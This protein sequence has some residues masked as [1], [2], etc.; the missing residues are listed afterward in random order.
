MSYGLSTLPWPFAEDEHAF[1]Y[2]VNVEE[3]RVHRD[4][5]GGAWGDH[6]IE[7]GDDYQ[8]LVR[9]RANVLAKDPARTQI[10]PHMMP[11]CWD[12]MHFLMGD[13]AA[14]YP[15]AMHHERDGDGWTWRN[16]LLGIEQRYV[17]GDRATLP[18]DP[19]TYI[20]RQVP[21]DILL[22][23]E[24]DGQLWFDAGIVTFANSWSVK[25][26]V[27]MS[28]TEIHGP[29][30]GMSGE[31]TVRRAEQFMRMITPGNVYRRVNWALSGVGAHR[32]DASLETYDQWAWQKSHII[33][34]RDWGRIRLRLELEHFLRLPLTGTLVFNIR[35]YMVTLAE[36]ATV[37]EWA[38]QLIEIAREVPEPIAEY[39]G[40]NGWRYE[41]MDWL[42]AE[43]ARLARERAA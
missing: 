23:R 4:T 17:L 25:F 16:D 1:R 7:V 12:V 33:E 26:D 41:A 32:M 34:E 20:G 21:D 30:P 35:T 31:G 39:K 9:A 10:L 38:T 5:A 2:S 11:A 37:P 18:E 43:V 14:S 29:V 27:G 24:R 6:V 22:V 36:L 13:L 42:E 28:F 3:A 40:I 8:D 15:E 19:L